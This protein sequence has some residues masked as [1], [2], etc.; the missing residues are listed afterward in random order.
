MDK[1]A[2]IDEEL[3]I[4]AGPNL[5]LLI[6]NLLTDVAVLIVPKYLQ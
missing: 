1:W 2:H 6:I 4:G 5:E 3:S